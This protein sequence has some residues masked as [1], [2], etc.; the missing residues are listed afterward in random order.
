[1]NKRN[2]PKLLSLILCAV[3]L[4]SA[5]IPV[6][7]RTAYADAAPTTLTLNCPSAVL[8]EASTGTVLFEQNPSAVGGAVPGD[9]FYYQR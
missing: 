6:S 1:M 5:E 3:L 9:D 2:I 4:V 8:M 7:A